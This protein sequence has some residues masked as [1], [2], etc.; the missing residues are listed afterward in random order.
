M[1]TMECDYGKSVYLGFYDV[2]KILSFPWLSIK[3]FTFRV[4]SSNYIFFLLGISHVVK[5]FYIKS[6]SYISL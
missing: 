6:K 5:N 3:R 2:V 1:F 4:K